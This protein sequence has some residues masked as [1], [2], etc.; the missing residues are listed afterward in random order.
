MQ[1]DSEDKKKS[2]E[3]GSNQSKTRGTCEVSM[4][5]S[6][7]AQ[8]ARTA[9]NREF[10]CSLCSPNSKERNKSGIAMSS[11]AATAVGRFTPGSAKTFGRWWH[12]LF[13]MPAWDPCSS[14]VLHISSQLPTNH[15]T[16]M[17]K[18]LMWISGRTRSHAVEGLSSALIPR[19][20]HSQTDMS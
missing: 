15:L 17:S 4:S 20:L 10:N 2:R 3:L 13:W 19:A 6:K 12:L 9:T 14:T 5:F 1:Y 8:A 11:F 7:Q 16:L 18:A